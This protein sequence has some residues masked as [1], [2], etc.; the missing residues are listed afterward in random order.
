MNPTLLFKGGFMAEMNTK[1][2]EL[3]KQS[4]RRD[5]EQNELKEV[6]YQKKIVAMSNQF[7]TAAKHLNIHQKRLIFMAISDMFSTAN[8]NN[9]LRRIYVNDYINTFTQVSAKNA[10]RDMKK[11]VKGLA[12]NAWTVRLDDGEFRY[13]PWLVDGG[14]K[15]K[16]GWAEIEFNPK[17]MIHLQNLSRDFTRY[18]LDF[19]EHI[20]TALAWDFLDLLIKAADSQ[21]TKENLTG[22]LFI[23]YQDLRDA[24]SV[25]DSYNAGMF[26]KRFLDKA[27]EEVSR[28]CNL[29]IVVEEVKKRNKIESYKIYFAPSQQ[30]PLI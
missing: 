3:M 13:I 16:E 30:L 6:E 27:I 29:D 20:E 22:R 10:Y 8:N 19:A 12:T 18:K 25:K 15:S 23:K 9:P 2:A 28:V 26:K 7:V 21:C 14:Y 24:L 5:A 1:I 11:A 4:A 17:T